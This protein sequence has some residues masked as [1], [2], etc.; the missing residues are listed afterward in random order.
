[1]RHRVKGKKFNRE[2]GPRRSFLRILV[3]NAIRKERIETTEARAK[4]IRPIIERSVTLAKKGTLAS[5]RLLLSRL[6]DEKV[7]KKLV[8]EIAPRYAK[9]AGGYLR[10]I[11]SARTRKRDGGSIAIIEFVK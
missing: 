3:N 4:A 1:M 7:V 9:R 10:I 5:R 2:T 6:H 11:K 8:E